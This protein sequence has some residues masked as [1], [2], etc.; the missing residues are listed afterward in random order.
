[1]PHS[2]FSFT[3]FSF[4]LHLLLF[5]MDLIIAPT[6]IAL[7]FSVV[8]IIS[9]PKL[10]IFLASLSFCLLDSSC[11]YLLSPW[12]PAHLPFSWYPT[13]LI[14]FV[15]LH[16]I[17]T[18]LFLFFLIGLDIIRTRHVAHYHLCQLNSHSVIFFVALTPLS[19]DLKSVSTA[20]FRDLDA[21]SRRFFPGIE[22][23]FCDLS[24]GLPTVQAE[25]FFFLSS[26][27]N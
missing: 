10:S 27:L 3:S 15:Y 6:S 25:L 16:I 5:F 13:C 18:C 17:N 26:D 2:S 9:L 22:S 19:P 20:D 7:T 12:F 23:A 8:M 4:L 14:H 24:L 1:M 21:T 11:T